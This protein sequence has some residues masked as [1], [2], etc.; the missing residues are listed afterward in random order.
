MSQLRWQQT[1]RANY[2]AADGDGGH[3]SIDRFQ[4][5][6][7]KIHVY[8]SASGPNGQPHTRQVPWRRPNVR[9]TL[10]EAQASCQHDAHLAE[11]ADA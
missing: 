5:T 6:W 8:Y 9:P 3:Y 1:G 11:R 2:R 7:V 10:A 4:R